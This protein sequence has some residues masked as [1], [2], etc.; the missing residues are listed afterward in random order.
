METLRIDRGGRAECVGAVFA[1]DTDAGA[2]MGDAVGG[3]WAGSI[4]G[5]GDRGWGKR[6]MVAAVVGLAGGVWEGG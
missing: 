4:E 3:G 6:D 5:A 2:D 1:G